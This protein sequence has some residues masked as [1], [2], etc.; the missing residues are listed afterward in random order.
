MVL[1][2]SAIINPPGHRSANGILEENRAV[3]LT[4]GWYNIRATVDAPISR[5]IEKGKLGLGYKIAVSGAKVRCSW[6]IV[7]RNPI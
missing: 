7:F 3:E 4:D 1:C 5:A 2:V 6:Q